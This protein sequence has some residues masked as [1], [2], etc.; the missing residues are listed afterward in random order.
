ML[1]KGL[2]E[3]LRQLGASGTTWTMTMVDTY[4]QD[5][6]KLEKLGLVQ[7]Q[8]R[9]VQRGKFRGEVNGHDVIVSP[10]GNALLLRRKR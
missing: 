3:A 5:A 4:Y 1:A 10:A 7:F 2:R 9:F 6:L 8:P